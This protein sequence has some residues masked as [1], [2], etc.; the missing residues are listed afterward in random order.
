MTPSSQE[1][2]SPAIPGRFKFTRLKKEGGAVW[3]Y[4]QNPESEPAPSDLAVVELVFKI[5]LPIS[6]SSKP[7]FSDYVDG[8]GQSH[9]RA[10]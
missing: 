6:M 8:K 7:D 2:E 1:L 10:N 4:R 3:Y 9:P 5:G